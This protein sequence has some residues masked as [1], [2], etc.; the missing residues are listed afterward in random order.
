VA[1]VSHPD[2][3]WLERLAKTG[4]PTVRLNLQG[5]LSATPASAANVVASIRGTDHPDEQVI[6]GAHLDSWDVAQG[7]V[8]NGTGAMAVL[9]AARLLKSVGSPPKRTLTFVLFYGE[10]QGEVGS[11]VFVRDHAGE[12]AKVDAVL[13]DDVGAGRIT[14]IPLESLWQAA[15]LLEEIY[16]PLQSVFDLKPMTNEYFAGSDHDPFYERGVPAFLAVQE[17]AH[18]GFAHH[19]TGDVFELV[20]PEALRQQS[21]VLAAWM[22]NVSEMPPALPHRPK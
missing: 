12:M 21:A 14:S 13:V 15:P 22:W 9:E 5:E 20:D 11:R 7:A 10:E 6:I 17:P 18:Y 19:S 3:L 8:D 2:Y 1:Y 4:A 16:A